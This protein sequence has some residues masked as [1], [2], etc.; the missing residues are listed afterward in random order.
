ME[1]AAIVS[2]SATLGAMLFSARGRCNRG[3]VICQ[4]ASDFGGN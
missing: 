2:I 3:T 4:M 1:T